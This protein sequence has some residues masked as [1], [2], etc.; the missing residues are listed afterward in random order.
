MKQVFITILLSILMLTS[1]MAAEPGKLTIWCSEVQVTILQK[2]GDE[3]EAMYGIPVVVQQVTFSDIRSKF[4]TAAPAG[5]GPDIIVGAH[6]WVGE[7]AANGL[8]LPLDYFNEKRRTEYVESALKGFEY[9]GKLYGL[10]YGS[11]AIGLIYNKELVPEPPK[12]MEELIS[13]AKSLTDGDLRGFVFNAGDFYFAAP[14]FFTAGGYVFKETPQGLDPKDIGLATQGAITGGN[15][16]KRMYDE[17]I[18]KPGDNYQIMDSLFKD[19]LAGMIIN[20]PWAIKDI[21]SAGIDYGVAAIPSI[22]GFNAKPF[23]GVQGFMI[24]SKSPNHLFALE[25]LANFLSQKE[26]MYKLYQAD[27]R[28]PTRLDVLEMVK[29]Q[30]DIIAFGE[31]AKYGTPMPNIPAMNAVWS[32]MAGALTQIINNLS[33][34]EQALKEAVDKVI[35]A[36]EQ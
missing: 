24:N 25:F 13:I 22:E 16:I 3:F 6:D 8:L 14:F 30:T 12:T 7:L 9:G 29:D 21:Q 4:L 15:L 11:E 32:A 23:I 27:P 36:L 33:S 34:P 17:G 28:I 2:L 19:G 26:I 31:S 20:G 35:L 18:M 5:E 10:P 1:L